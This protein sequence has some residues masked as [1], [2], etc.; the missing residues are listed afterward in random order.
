M[1]KEEQ[2][3]A[4]FDAWRT[5]G[6]PRATFAREHGLPINSFHYWCQRFEGKRPARRRD[7]APEARAGSTPMFI[8]VK[9]PARQPQPRMRF[10]LPD[11][12]SITIY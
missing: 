6:K 1:S 7:S 5:S 8:E 9:E 10:E 4:L 2:M 3:R 11:G 12:L